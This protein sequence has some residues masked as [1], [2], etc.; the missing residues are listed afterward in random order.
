M[1]G[2]K[3]VLILYAKGVHRKN[4]RRILIVAAN[5][6]TFSEWLHARRVQPRL[7]IVQSGLDPLCMHVDKYPFQVTE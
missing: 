2:E 1:L 4:L 6:P 5:A 3:G 7:H